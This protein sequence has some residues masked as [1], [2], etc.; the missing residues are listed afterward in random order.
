MTSGNANR[1]VATPSRGKRTATGAVTKDLRTLDK[2]REL[3]QLNDANSG[4]AAE[5]DDPLARSKLLAN[6]NNDG[7]LNEKENESCGGG[8]K[9]AAQRR[10]VT[11]AI[12]LPSNATGE[13]HTFDAHCNRAITMEQ[14]KSVVHDLVSWAPYLHSK[15][16]ID[17]RL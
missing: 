9:L 4:D 6:N 7:A 16:L 11:G 3:E 17:A 2:R 5:L 1:A 12:R 13:L 10:D 8:A 14:L 15:L